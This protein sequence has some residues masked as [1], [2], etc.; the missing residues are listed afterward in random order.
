MHDFSSSR[1]S[2]IQSADTHYQRA[3]QAVSECYIAV[4][5]SA[6]TVFG[7]RQQND[8]PAERS[9]NLKAACRPGKTIKCGRMSARAEGTKTEDGQSTPLPRRSTRNFSRPLVHTTS[10]MHL[11]DT[12][13]YSPMPTPTLNRSMSLMDLGPGKDLQNVKGFFSPIK[14]ANDEATKAQISPITPPET[15]LRSTASDDDSTP[16]ASQKRA[17]EYNLQELAC[18]EEPTSPSSMHE[19]DYTIKAKTFHNDAAA[20]VAQLQAHLDKLREL[21]TK[22]EAAQAERSAKRSARSAGIDSRVM[23]SSRSY[24]SFDNTKVGIPGKMR[25]IEEGRARQWK[26]ERVDVTRY[27]RLAETAMAELGI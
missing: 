20:F 14:E 16:I 17:F 25:Q 21:K 9:P 22:T 4:G 11:E 2:R 12:R 24:W 5:S 8:S 15:P 3:I 10:Q 26:R 18:A 1:L 19:S 23:Q 7:G 27:Q 6:E 13:S